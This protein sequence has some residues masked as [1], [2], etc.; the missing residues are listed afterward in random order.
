M[1]DSIELADGTRVPIEDTVCRCNHWYE[2]HDRPLEL[3]NEHAFCGAPGCECAGF[4]ADPA[5][6]SPETIAD[7]GG[8]PGLWPEHVKAACG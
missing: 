3:G 1:S 5:L 2:E 4:V 8:D 7:R 6:S